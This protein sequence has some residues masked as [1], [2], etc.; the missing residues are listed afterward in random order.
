[1]K[2]VRLAATLPSTT[3]F[4]DITRPEVWLKKRYFCEIGRIKPASAPNS[5][6][7]T[8]L[9]TDDLV[10][11]PGTALG[12][13]AV[14]PVPNGIAAAVNMALLGGRSSRRCAYL[15]RERSCLCRTVEGFMS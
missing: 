4:L 3:E 5:K 11:R 9:M 8:A 10:S 6:E 12:T 13:I 2:S 1:M 15:A 14:S 7:A